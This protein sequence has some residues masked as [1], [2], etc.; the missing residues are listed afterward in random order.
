MVVGEIS[1]A[2][3]VVI[4]GGG[5]AGY[6]A[7]IRAAQHGEDVTLIEKAELGGICLNHGC[8]P[9]KA[10]I[11]AAN[12]V[13]SL[14]NAATFGVD[15]DNVTLDPTKLQD[16]KQDVVDTLTGGVEALEKNHGVEIIKGTAAFRGNETI[17]VSGDG[18]TDTISFENCIIA[19]G[20]T[21]IML[22]DVDPSHD[23]IITSREALQ[24]DTIPDRL[25]IIGGGYIG[26]EL[27]FVYQKLGSDVTIIEGQDRILTHS[28]ADAATV[29]AES[30]EEHGMDIK[31]ETMVDTVE[32]GDPTTIEAGGDTIEADTVLVAIGR[33]PQ[34]QG[35]RLRRTDVETTDDGFIDVNEKLETAASHIY[36]IGDVIDQPMLAHKAYQQANVA[37]ANAAGEDTIINYQSIPACIYT[38]PEVATVG[39][40]EQE[41]QANGYDVITGS[42]DMKHNG[43]ALTL[44]DTNGFVKLIAT[45]DDH[46]LLGATLCGPHVSEL[47]AELTFAIEMGARVEDLSLTIHPHPTLSEAVQEAADDLR[48]QP[49]HKS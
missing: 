26:M 42:F 24:L 21:P 37:G 35:L 14:Q 23:S 39:F 38:D 16:W 19:T 8:I 9:S 28:P 43:R 1:E 20:S 15:A 11:H 47:I 41:A 18:E 48:G 31:T 10:V 3:D 4:I 46:I 22:P 40:S 17:H 32:P 6:A 27:G 7:A 12:T 13:D 33:T 2:R 44:D 49:L 45:E 5:P 36:A 25:A 30:A 34:T 29:V